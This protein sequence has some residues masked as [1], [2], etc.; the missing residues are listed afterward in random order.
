MANSTNVILRLTQASKQLKG[1]QALD[2]VTLELNRGET[3]A[4]T[5]P[6]GSGKSTLLKL[7]AG[8]S[9][10]SSGRRELPGRGD[11]EELVI[12][13]AP[14]HLPKLKFTAREY[15]YHMASIRGLQDPARTR[16]VEEL[17]ARVE[18]RDRPGQQMKYFSKGMLQ[19]VNFVQALL[20][21][22]E[23]LLL[24]EPIG[25]L[26]E[27]A[28]LVLG[29]TLRLLRQR[30]TAIVIAGH[31]QTLLAQWADRIVQIG[32]GRIV[33]VRPAPAQPE[34]HEWRRIV[35]RWPE[36]REAEADAWSGRPEPGLLRCGRE[37][38]A[39]V[40]W[41][42]P[43]GSDGLLRELLASGASVVS[44]TPGQGRLS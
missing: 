1:K 41:S 14:D 2:R 28:Q 4:L 22:P 30:G 38:G 27:E 26:D 40:Y 33:G 32:E 31:E 6:N 7:L 19:K 25:G 24:D 12:G 15:L 17:L 36:G 37:G 29:E 23:L 44:V 21:E 9:A 16:R 34:R 43:E 20:G 11:G 5:G 13:Y 3:V 39:A 35:C 8:L 18:L 42:E 10:P